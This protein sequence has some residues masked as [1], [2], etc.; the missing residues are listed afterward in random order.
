V[1]GEVF[2]D[3]GFHSATI[4]QIC[5]RA[6]ANVAA[7]NYHFGDKEKLYREVV[8]LAHCCAIKQ[9]PEELGLPPGTPADQRLHATVHTL[10]KRLLDE[11]RP[12]WQG[13]LMAREMVDPTGALDRLI[14]QSI[15]PQF[16]RLAD[17]VRAALVTRKPR[18][19]TKP[20][21]AARAKRVDAKTRRGALKRGRRVVED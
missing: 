4:R 11:G 19:A 16:E 21:R 17:L 13:K 12:A 8:Q 2:A 3:H 15:H 9:F 14:E 18:K 1:A 6:G 10:L 5:D 7:V 20:S